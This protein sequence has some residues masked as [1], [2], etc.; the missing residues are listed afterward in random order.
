MGKWLTEL[1]TAEGE[2]YFQQLYD[3]SPWEMIVRHELNLST[4]LNYHNSSIRHIVFLEYDE[5]INQIFTL[6]EKDY[7]KVYSE[8]RCDGLFNTDGMAFM[9]F[10]DPKDSSTVAFYSVENSPYDMTLDEVVQ[11][12]DTSAQ[13]ILDSIN[14]VLLK[15]EVQQG[16]SAENVLFVRQL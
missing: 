6:E 3:M 13:E 11:E 7:L 15:Y 9:H 1:H 2:K 10:I 12:S 16:A 4:N 5:S 14:R 8:Q